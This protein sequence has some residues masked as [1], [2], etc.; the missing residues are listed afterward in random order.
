MKAGILTIGNEVSSGQI[1][2]SNAA[3]VSQRLEWLK[4]NVTTHVTVQDEDRQILDA[5]EFVGGRTDI[6]FITG[7]LGPTRDDLTRHSVCTWLGDNLVFDEKSWDGIC[8]R[9]TAIG[10]SI[11]ESN[12]QQCYFPRNSRILNNAAGT[13]NGFYSQKGQQHIW[14]LPGP[15]REIKQIWQDH[16]DSQLET[17]FRNKIRGFSLS[18]WQCLGKSESALGELVESAIEGSTL[19]SGYR[20][21]I[22]FVEVKLWSP[23]EDT[24]RNRPFMEAVEQA[25]KPW[26]VC[27][28]D[29]DLASILADKISTYES[30]KVF[31][32][33]SSGYL[34]YRLGHVLSKADFKGQIAY[35]NEWS[36][37]ES[38]QDL[39][40]K[41][42]ELAD[43]E[44][45]TL[46]LGPV[47][48]DGAWKIGMS[49]SGFLH[50]D[51]LKS[52]YG[53]SRQKEKLTKMQVELSLFKWP[54]L[55]EQLESSVS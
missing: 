30:I 32:F 51:T 19:T 11:S 43:P 35:L 54:Q 38:S 23:D 7:G 14:C 49:F 1:V 3:W 42:L 34:G 4:L 29:E 44:T 22:P 46:C 15:P 31:D 28:E 8:Q 27:R 10:V 2:N 25:I 12:R 40:H 13:A 26:L 5:L 37:L 55:L 6:I 17:L 53:K 52:Y 21:H 45:L 36:D 48:I 39:V 41:C 20:P 24:E 33:S 16:I 47:N 18:R 50:I 9:L